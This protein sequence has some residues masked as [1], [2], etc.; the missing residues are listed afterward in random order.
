MLKIE[1]PKIEEPKIEEPKKEIPDLKRSITSKTNLN[2]NPLNKRFADMQNML[3][4][5]M[6]KGMI[7]GVPKPKQEGEKIEHNAP[8][9]KDQSTYED[10]IKSSKSLVKKKKPKRNSR[11]GVGE[12]RIQ[13]PVKPSQDEGNKIQEGNEGNEPEENNKE[14]KNEESKIEE[15]NSETNKVNDAPSPPKPSEEKGSDIKNSVFNLFKEDDEPKKENLFT[16]VE[17]DSNHE[18]SNNNQEQND[19]NILNNDKLEVQNSQVILNDNINK[20]EEPTNK[21]KLAFFDDDDE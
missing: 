5:K 1:E 12:E 14:P 7:M 18:P 8:A 19:F 4:N 11:F 16:K 21:K 10:V 9:D 13:I 2:K 6:G 20:K 15:Q 17:L 3:S